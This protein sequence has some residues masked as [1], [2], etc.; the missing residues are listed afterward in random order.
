MMFVFC[1]FFVV[2]VVVFVFF[3]V[4]VVV[5]FFKER[6]SPMHIPPRLLTNLTNELSLRT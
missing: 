2:V 4:V 3:V 5:V 6:L 1:F